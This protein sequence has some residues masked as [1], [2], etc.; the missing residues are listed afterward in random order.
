MDLIFELTL[1]PL[2]WRSLTFGTL[3]VLAI[4][5]RIAI[6]WR[7]SVGVRV[8]RELLVIIPAVLLYFMVRGLVDGDQ[9]T[10]VRHAQ[11]IIDLEQ[12]L[13]IWVE[14]DLQRV[15]LESA[16]RTD[17][18]NWVYIWA[19]WPVIALVIFWL[20]LR[21]FEAY[22]KYRNALLISGVAGM[23]IF[24]TYPVAP[25][26]LM[27]DYAFIDTVTAQS[28]S[29]R[30]LQPPAL[31]NPYAA[32]PSL[33]FGWNLLMGI[34]LVRESRRLSIR[35]I[36]FLIPIAMFLAIVISANHYIL[37]GVVG[38]ALV[39]ASLGVS[40]RLPSASLAPGSLRSWLRRERQRDD[41]APG[42]RPIDGSR[43]PA[44]GERRPGLEIFRR[45]FVVAHRFGNSLNALE[46]AEWAGA[47]IVE[48]DVWPYRG[49][50][51]VRHTKTLGP[52]P[53]LWDRWSLDP[54]WRPR[55]Q[56]SELLA[57]LAPDTLLMI[58]VKGRDPTAAARIIEALRDH[59]PGQPVLVCS[60]NWEQVDR[61]RHYEPALQVYSI[62]NGRQLRRAMR[63]LSNEDWDVVSIQ[64]RLL[65]ERVVRDLKQAGVELVMTWPINTQE[66]FERVSRFGVDGITSDDLN[67]I[68]GL[69]ARRQRRASGPIDIS[70]LEGMPGHE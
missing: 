18:V 19:H 38:G 36:G 24:A 17:L 27:P 5:L 41:H 47:D 59:R 29:Y 37:D 30:V 25:P 45:P 39:L 46:L 66:R 49:R 40:T 35:I 69:A 34:A 23:I 28:N 3:I 21:H 55:L 15:V 56:L 31:T 70:A 10:A 26:R 33:H 14:P 60:Q 54:G 68:A 8:L 48:A 4:V 20:V 7:A 67:L 43:R 53:V 65:D 58:D 61:F 1:N 6:P 16:W 63:R 52:L 57:A 64:A 62:G 9:E 42:L 22:P 13:G 11:Q 32:M 50:L 12:W 44:G 51:E 2:E